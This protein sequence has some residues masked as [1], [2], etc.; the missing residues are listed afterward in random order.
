MVLRR[1]KPIHRPCADSNCNK[2]FVRHPGSRQVLC[3]SCI[4]KR[5]FEWLKKRKPKEGTKTYQDR[6]Q[7][8]KR[9]KEQLPSLFETQLN[10]GGKTK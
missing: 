3:N 1:T 4:E 2:L 7:V 5:K 9:I 10:Q 8:L 6:Q